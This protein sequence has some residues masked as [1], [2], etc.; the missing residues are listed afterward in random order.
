MAGLSPSDS[1]TINEDFVAGLVGGSGLSFIRGRLIRSNSREVFSA[2][3]G[4]R[5]IN[6][7]GEIY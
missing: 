2:L 7:S 6:A 4:W 1:M 3:T 5:R